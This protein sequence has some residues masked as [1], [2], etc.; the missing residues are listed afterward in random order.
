MTALCYYVKY[1]SRQSAPCPALIET[2]TYCSQHGDWLRACCCPTQA[3]PSAVAAYKIKSFV[4]VAAAKERPLKP[5]TQ[6]TS[7]C[8][9]SYF[10]YGCIFLDSNTISCCI[11]SIKLFRALYFGA[12]LIPHSAMYYYILYV[13]LFYQM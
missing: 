13:I 2:A 10:F 5:P 1:R 9:I 3:P 6:N 7:F 4:P 12:A 8:I 11:S